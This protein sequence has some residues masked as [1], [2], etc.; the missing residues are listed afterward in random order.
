[1]DAMATNIEETKRFIILLRK[2]LK[3]MYRREKPILVMDQHPSHK[4]RKIMELIEPYFK[5]LIQPA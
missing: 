1:M 5:V 4:S 3:N 2:S